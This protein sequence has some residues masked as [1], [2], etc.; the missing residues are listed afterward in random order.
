MKQLLELHG[1]VFSDAASGD[2][3]P[4]SRGMWFSCPGCLP[5]TS[6]AGTTF[7]ARKLSS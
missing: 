6:L 4:D 2:A 5:V 7:S 1:F 3:S